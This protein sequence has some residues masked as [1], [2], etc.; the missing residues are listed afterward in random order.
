MRELLYIEI[1]T[2]DL[3]AV[4]SWLQEDFE[5]ELGEKII[6]PEG[7]RL[8]LIKNTTQRFAGGGSGDALVQALE[9]TI[10]ETPKKLACELSVF[11]WSALQTTYLK[12][13]RWADQPIPGER[14]ILQRLSTKLRSRFP[15]RYPEP[16]VVDLQQQSI[17]AALAPHYPLTVKYFQKMP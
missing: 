9:A 15:H 12:V 16:P 8:R 2:P 17:F 7:F 10:S 5:P 1:P 14:K 3:R 4:R 6:T 13:F 11:V